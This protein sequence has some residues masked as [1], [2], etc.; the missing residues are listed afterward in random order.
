MNMTP[1]AAKKRRLE[2]N[3]NSNDS[4]AV[5]IEDDRSSVADYESSRLVVNTF[6][7]HIATSDRLVLVHLAMESIEKFLRDIAEN[8]ARSRESSSDKQQFVDTF[9][10]LGGCEIVL[11][12]LQRWITIGLAT[13][14]GVCLDDDT[15]AFASATLGLFLRMM[16]V[17]RRTS[18]C[19]LEVAGSRISEI[20]L[21]ICKSAPMDAAILARVIAIWGNLMLT[22][23]R[24]GNVLTENVSSLILN[25]MLVHPE[26]ESIQRNGF[27]F[28]ALLP[29]M[30]KAS[31][32]SQ[33]FD[34]PKLRHV[35][36]QSLVS[37]QSKKRTYHWA[38]KCTSL[39]NA[40]YLVSDDDDCLS[41]SVLQHRRVDQKV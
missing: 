11:H 37:Y 34:R 2:S 32:E 33:F 23:P 30:P 8:Q 31:R 22:V 24:N 16:K 5:A 19:I 25:M 9:L 39:Y 28:F 36:Q 40:G 38:R 3:N 21:L 15:L 7:L 14:N 12:A 6:L 20:L 17:N 41:T 29:S 26:C 35:I 10:E 4:K 13:T 18:S 27:K 1:P